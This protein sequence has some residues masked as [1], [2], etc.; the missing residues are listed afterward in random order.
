MVREQTIEQMER[1]ARDIMPRLVAPPE[2]V[3]VN[4]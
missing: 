1:F 2:P 4:A 3:G